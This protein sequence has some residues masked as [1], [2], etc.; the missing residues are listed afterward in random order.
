MVG[1]LGTRFVLLKPP[2]FCLT[3]SHD[4]YPN[5]TWHVNSCMAGGLLWGEKESL[6]LGVHRKVLT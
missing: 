3:C 5:E 4:M 1:D 6:K 2:W